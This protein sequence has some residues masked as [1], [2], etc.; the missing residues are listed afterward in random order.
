MAHTIITR[1]YLRN[2]IG[3]ETDDQ[4]NAFIA[5]LIGAL[6]DFT[7]F[8]PSDIKNLCSSVRKPGWTIELPDPANA[9][10]NRRIQNPGHNI[11]DLCKT[12]MVLTAYG[13][14]IYDMIGRPIDPNSLLTNILKQIKHH[15]KTIENHN[16]PDSLPEV[17]KLFDIMKAIDMFT[18]FLSEKLEVNKVALSYVIQEHDVSGVPSFLVS[19]RPYGTVYT[20]LMYELISHAPHDGPAFAEDNATVLRLLQYILAD[21]SHMSS[22]KPFQRTRDGRGAFQDTQRHNMGKYK[23]DKVLED[24]ESMVQTRAWNGKNSILPLKAHI[25]KHR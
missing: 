16:N 3:L 25:N 9:N 18:T 11:P 21:T 7:Q 8:Q 24:A 5:E 13:S 17:R 1:Q 14:E 15:R 2:I 22:M 19:N 20:Q 6:E 10:R 23:W 12:R 4:A